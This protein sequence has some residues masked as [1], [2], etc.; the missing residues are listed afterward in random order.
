MPSAWP[1]RLLRGGPGTHCIH[2][3]GNRL[4]P[5]SA[6]AL[7]QR[8]GNSTSND[9]RGEG[10]LGQ[11]P[12]LKKVLVDGGPHSVAEL[13]IFFDRFKSDGQGSYVPERRV[14]A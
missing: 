6:V 3:S 11:P 14:L 8:Q 5:P 7:T 10:N 1:E 12:T 9:F 13:R 2:A 4:S